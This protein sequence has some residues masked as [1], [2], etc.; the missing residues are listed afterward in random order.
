[1]KEAK[2]F[3]G[4]TINVGCGVAHEAIAISADVRGTNI[5]TPDDEDIGFALGKIYL[6][7]ASHHKQ[8]KK[9]LFYFCCN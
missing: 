7:D 4:D 1:M 9:L 6:A 2:T 3:I 5:I 8:K